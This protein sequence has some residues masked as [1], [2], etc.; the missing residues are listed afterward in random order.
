MTYNVFSGTLSPTQSTNL[1]A[2]LLRHVLYPEIAP[3][4]FAWGWIPR[5]IHASLGLPESAT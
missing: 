4:Q 1:V 3:S 2:Q 5:L